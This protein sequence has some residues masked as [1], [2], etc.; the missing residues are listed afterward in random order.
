MTAYVDRTLGEGVGGGGDVVHQP[1]AAERGGRAGEG[2]AE[3]GEGRGG[4]GGGRDK[5]CAVREAG[6]EGGRGLGP[7]RE[8]ERGGA[9]GRSVAGS[10]TR[11]GDVAGGEA[12]R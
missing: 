10:Q 2:G 9:P 12:G 1:C 5:G 3:G 6:Q 4:R 11:A 8:R 7:E